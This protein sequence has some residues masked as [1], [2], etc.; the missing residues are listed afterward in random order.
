[1]EEEILLLAY[2]EKLAPWVILYTIV[3]YS[4]LVTAKESR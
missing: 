2:L 1:M 3:A 4:A